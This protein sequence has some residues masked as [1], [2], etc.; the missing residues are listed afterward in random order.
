MTE[1]NRDLWDR[2]TPYHLRSAFYDVAGFKA[3]RDPLDHLVLETLGDVQGQSLLHLQ[4]HFGLDSL[5]LVRR[6]AKVTGVD[7]SGVSIAAARELARE[8][9]LDACFVESDVYHLPSNLRG[10]FDIVFASHGVLCWLPYLAAW[11]RVVAHFLKPGGRFCLV[12][13]HPF[14][15]IFD[16]HRTDG[17]LTLREPYFFAGEPLVEEVS[18][19]AVRE[20]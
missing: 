15:M 4:C 1:S 5:A 2:W 3:G 19:P 10:E 8:L 12:D 17:V 14:A 11:A 7:F 6:G 9:N 18:A 13:G 16:E 20:G